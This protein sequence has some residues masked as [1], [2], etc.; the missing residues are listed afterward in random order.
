MHA[1]AAMHIPVAERSSCVCGVAA[2]SSCV[3]GVNVYT[4]YISRVE[5]SCSVLQYA[6]AVS[7]IVLHY[8]AV[9]QRVAVCCSVL[10]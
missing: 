10:Q 3:C 9:L 6:A 4:V 8:V 2:R 7:C 1:A 5:D